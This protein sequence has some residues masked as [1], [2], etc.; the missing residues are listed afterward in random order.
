MEVLKELL[1]W[2]LPSGFVSSLL[3]WL[4]TR[5]KRRNDF[6]T[7]LQNSIDLLTK[8]YTETLDKYTISQE[9][10]ARLKLDNA[11]LLANQEIMARKID[12]LN[13]KVDQLNKLLKAT[14]NEKFNQGNTAASRRTSDGVVRIE[15][16]VFN[17]SGT[18][19]TGRDQIIP[20]RL[21]GKSRVRKTGAN[22]SGEDTG[23]DESDQGGIGGDTIR[24][25]ADDDTDSEPP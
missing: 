3:T 1:I 22:A 13:K 17:D 4:V 2:A 15:K 23:L 8:K 24:G 11:Q 12:Q 25:V 14:N 10:N 7:D 19:E 5:K 18:A 21:T 16:A 20:A 6:L 9:E